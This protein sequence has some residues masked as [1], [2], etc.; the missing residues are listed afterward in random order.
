MRHT[1]REY[2]Q[3]LHH[4]R[5][6]VLLMG[7]RVEEMTKSA[8]QAFARHDSELAKATIA[9]DSEIDRLE[10]DIDELCVRVLARR[11]PVASDLRFI[12]TTLKIVTDLERMGDL[13]AGVCERVLDLDAESLKPVRAS[14]VQMGQVVSD[15]QHEAL[16]AF[17]QGDAAR[18][19]R[20]MQRDAVVDATYARIFPELLGHMMQD[21]TTVSTAQK[22][23]SVAKN[24][25]RLADHA[26]N[27][28]EMVVFMVRGEDK[29]H[30]GKVVR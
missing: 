17:I 24:L 12:T 28:G 15:M 27:L 11:Q 29:R 19:E 2:E 3:E 14:L 13:A 21:P 7:A 1:D 25:E 22:L 20:V 18:A 6:A 30:A 9:M 16:D 8:L 26:T 5:D 10:M 23:Q 4:L